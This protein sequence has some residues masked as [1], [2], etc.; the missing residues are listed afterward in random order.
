L[1]EIMMLH[2]KRVLTIFIGM[3]LIGLFAVPSVFG[4]MGSGATYS[5]SWFVAPSNQNTIYEEG[6]VVSGYYVVGCGVT[7]ETYNNYGHACS[8]NT[9]L[10]SPNG[11]IASSSFSSD[12][13]YAQAEAAID[14]DFND[15]E[16]GEFSVE[17]EHSYFCPIAYRDFNLGAS[18]DIVIVGSSLTCYVKDGSG[19]GFDF[20]DLVDGC[21]EKVT[22]AG[23]GEFAFPAGFGANHILRTEFWV[24]VTGLPRVCTNKIFLLNARHGCDSDYC[25]DEPPKN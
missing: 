14:W 16:P 13:S 20:Y 24:T 1:E 10:T 19:S 4:Q 22:C 9:T 5:D 7:D 18:Y 12:G 25:T 15:P 6:D 3:L 8:V 2:T 21:R 17:S 23:P 11:H